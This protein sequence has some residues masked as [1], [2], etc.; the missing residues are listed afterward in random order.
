MS[1]IVKTLTWGLRARRQTDKQQPGSICA[2]ML[3]QRENGMTAGNCGSQPPHT[4]SFITNS[5]LQ[6]IY[7]VQRSLLVS[8]YNVIYKDWGHMAKIGH[9]GKHLR[10]FE[11]AAR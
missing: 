4:K 9:R 2:H 10:L 3:N 6:Y 11:E 7:L 1:H 5:N 8:S